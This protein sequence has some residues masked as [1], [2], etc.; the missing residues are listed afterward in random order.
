M[1]LCEIEQLKSK[2]ESNNTTDYIT[3]DIVGSNTIEHESELTNSKNKIKEGNTYKN[4][5]I[6]D[7]EKTNKQSL[8][9]ISKNNIHQCHYYNTDSHNNSSIYKKGKV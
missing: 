1:F 6:F 3:K 4:R 9:T 2:S 7:K 8:K 5:N